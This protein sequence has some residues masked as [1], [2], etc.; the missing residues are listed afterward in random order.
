MHATS[1][2]PLALV[3]ASA[4]CLPL[5][6]TL[7][8]ANPAET[9]LLGGQLSSTER[10]SLLDEDSQA[11]FLSLSGQW[12]QGDV[13]L[14][15]SAHWGR[16][17]GEGQGLLQRLGRVD[18]SSWQLAAQWQSFGLALQQPLR[19]E[20]ARTQV[21]LAQGYVGNQ[22]NLQPVNLDLTPDGRQLDLEVF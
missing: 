5:L 12:Q 11:R 18:S 22:F 8:V 21:M 13:R 19:V 7:V 14:M 15:H 3:I 1:P 4:L 6:P 9:V 16:S 10:D 17:H 2:V 20:S